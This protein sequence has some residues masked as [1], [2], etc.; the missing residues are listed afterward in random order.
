MTIHKTVVQEDSNLHADYARNELELDIALSVQL[1][2]K[3]ASIWTF[4][5]LCETDALL[6]RDKSKKL[7]DRLEQQSNEADDI[8]AEIDAIVKDLRTTK[9]KLTKRLKSKLFSSEMKVQTSIVNEMVKEQTQIIAEK[10]FEENPKAK[11]PRMPIIKSDI[12][13]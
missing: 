4:N 9:R 11:K 7:I 10:F 8:R 1:K 13:N 3:Q 2:L 5:A 12:I 6:D